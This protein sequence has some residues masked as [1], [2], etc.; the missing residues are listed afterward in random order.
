MLIDNKAGFI[1]KVILWPYQE[2]GIFDFA[3]TMVNL[4]GGQ[5]GSLCWICKFL[6]SCIKHIM[7]IGESPKREIWCV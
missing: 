2:V 4:K 1:S 3:K 5:M 7:N 6:V